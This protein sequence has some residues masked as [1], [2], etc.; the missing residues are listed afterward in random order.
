MPNSDA[1]S[2][3]SQ[4][5]VFVGKPKRQFRLREINDLAGG[6][7]AGLWASLRPSFPDSSDFDAKGEGLSS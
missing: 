5:H 6:W 2:S 7:E 1:E 4:N 3:P